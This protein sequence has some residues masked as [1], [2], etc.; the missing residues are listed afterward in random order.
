MPMPNAR[1]SLTPHLRVR[2]LEPHN[3]ELLLAAELSSILEV[4]EYRMCSTRF[5]IGF[6]VWSSFVC[7]YN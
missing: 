2:G 1:L 6:Q 7:T 5:Y 3:L 4:R